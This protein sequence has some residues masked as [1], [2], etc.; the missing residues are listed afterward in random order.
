MRNNRSA[1]TLIELMLVVA[2][3]GL[4]AAI[5]IP[6]F[7]NMVVKAKEAAVIGKLGALRSAISIYYADNEGRFP[8]QVDLRLLNGKYM[9]EIPRISIPTVPAHAFNNFSTMDPIGDWFDYA[10]NYN[11]PNL[12]GNCKVNIHCTHTD[13]K[14]TTWSL[15]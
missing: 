14:G 1:F 3:I 2:I 12:S 10:Y 9:E 5:A 7:A 6:K 13:S 15:Y 8:Q 11:A 4:L